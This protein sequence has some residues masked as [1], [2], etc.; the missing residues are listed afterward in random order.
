G[1]VVQYRFVRTAGVSQSSPWQTLQWQAPDDPG[2]TQALLEPWE[3]MVNSGGQFTENTY[4]VIYRDSSPNQNQ[5]QPSVEATA[6]R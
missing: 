1:T 3:Y 4:V 2:G 6:S 5:T